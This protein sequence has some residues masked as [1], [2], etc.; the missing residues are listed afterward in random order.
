MPNEFDPAEAVRYAFDRTAR[1]YD[2]ARRMLVPCFDVFYG[3][4]LDQLRFPPDAAPRVL[5]LG[6]GTGLVAA[7]VRARYPRA[8]LTLVDIAPK[9]L[10]LARKRFAEDETGVR[11]VVADYSH[12]DLDAEYDTV[13]S[14]LSIHHL[15]DADK[16]GLFQRVRKALV[17]GGIFV[18]ADQVLGRT[19]DEDRMYWEDW[20]REARA[21]GA[22]NDDI[23][24]AQ[25]R[26]R[27]DRTAPL[28]SQLGWLHAA[29]FQDVACHF[30]WQAFAVYSGRA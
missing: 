23:A 1:E 2:R 16:A 25:E 3:A 4:L 10:D 22:T 19:P 13:V 11:F 17:P 12:E 7:L 8:T 5:D 14:A 30:Q 28:A 15:T 21:L 9:M 20:E 29:G 18:N 24:M 6:A 27:E 26:M